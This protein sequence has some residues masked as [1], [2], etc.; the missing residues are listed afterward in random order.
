[1]APSASPI[2]YPNADDSAEGLIEQ[3][4][5]LQKNDKAAKEQWD[6]FTDLEGKGVRDPKR[7]TPEFLQAF[8][9]HLSSGGRL[10]P[11]P[12]A[13]LTQAIKT[14]QKKCTPFKNVWAQFC[15]MN[16]GG[17]ND[18]AKH[19]GNFH[20][21][22]FEA[23]S[24]A[25][26]G[27]GM[28]MAGGGD[29]PMKRMKTASGMGMGTSF[30]GGPKEAL[31]NRLKAFQ[32]SGN[33]QKELWATYADRFLGGVRDP[34]RHDAPTLEEFCT[35]HGVPEIAG[36]CGGPMGPAPWAKEWAAAVLCPRAWTPRWRAS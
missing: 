18:P 13:D 12:E 23:L 32:R 17:M 4:K 21:K 3:V 5:N 2:L 25:A 27:G 8:L 6:A 30:G 15:A 22:F 20:M 24:Q 9:T 1:M 11:S 29:N 35:N 14:L 10:A 26:G 36:G 16:G 34:S 7:H 19:D 33:D 28:A 31:V